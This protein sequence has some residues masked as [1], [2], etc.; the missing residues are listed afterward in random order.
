MGTDMEC[1]VEVKKPDGTWICISGDLN[2]PRSYDLFSFLCGGLF[3]E[4]SPVPKRGFPADASA[5][6]KRAASDGQHF[7]D[8]WINL[9]EM[10]KCLKD[11]LENPLK[12]NRDNNLSWWDR[13][14]ENLDALNTMIFQVEKAQKVQPK[15]YEDTRIVFWLDRS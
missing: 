6:V 3:G 2:V 14:Q 8:N 4:I 12:K 1:Y 15:S 5:T 11:E 10:N 7:H 13:V 9:H